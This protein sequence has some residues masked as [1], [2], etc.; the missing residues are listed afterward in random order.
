MNKTK[1]VI[2]FKSSTEWRDWLEENHLISKVVWVRIFKKNSKEESVTYNEAIDEAL[3]YGW[4]DGQKD[5]YDALSWL[6]KF[7]PRR[8]G[9]NW[10]KNNTAN[11]ERLIISGKMKKAGLLK[12]EEAKSDGRWENA[13][14]PQSTA[15]LPDDFSR[16]L[17]K[18]TKAKRFFETLNKTNLYAIKYRLQTANK[19]ETRKKRIKLILTMLSEEKKFH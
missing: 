13:Y 18:N 5:K 14:H 7:T 19:I 6:Q 1:L 12:V 3:C 9:S 17:E 10:S 11:V 16:E 8:A 4:I 15:S 2:A